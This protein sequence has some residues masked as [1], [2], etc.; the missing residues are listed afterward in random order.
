MTPNYSG[1]DKGYILR[2]AVIYSIEYVLYTRN[3]TDSYLAST[4][5]RKDGSSS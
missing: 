2:C 1:R 3:N 5:L 4:G